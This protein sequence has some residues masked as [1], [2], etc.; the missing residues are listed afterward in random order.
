MVR[1]QDALQDPVAVRTDET[2][3]T[4]LLLRMLEVGLSFEQAPIVI[5]SNE[6]DTERSLDRLLQRLRSHCHELPRTP[7]QQRP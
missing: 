2:L 6:A 1:V 7:R 4:V 3:I 5:P